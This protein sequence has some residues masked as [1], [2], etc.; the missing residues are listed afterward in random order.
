MNTFDGSETPTKNTVNNT[1]IPLA[2]GPTVHGT[3]S[4]IWTRNLHQASNQT[5]R[6]LEGYEY[7]LIYAYGKSSP[8]DSKYG[9]KGHKTIHLE[10]SFPDDS[11][12]SVCS[13]L[14]LLAI[15]LII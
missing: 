4:I 13:L 9:G 3:L 7:T 10:N 8:S 12:L 14:G 5:I 6:I 1:I 11:A 15:Q 2:W